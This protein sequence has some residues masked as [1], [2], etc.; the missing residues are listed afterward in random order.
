MGLFLLSLG[1]SVG[2]GGERAVEKLE[3]ST[4]PWKCWRWH[5]LEQQVMAVPLPAARVRAGQ[6]RAIS[7]VCGAL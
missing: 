3:R 4:L 1:V 7:F 5:G 2:G 6:H